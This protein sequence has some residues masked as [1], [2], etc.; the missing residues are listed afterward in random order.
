ML[1]TILTMTNLTNLE[2]AVLTNLVNS[3]FGE[4][5]VGVWAFEAA[6]G[7]VSKKSVA[8]VV[9]SLSKK[10]LVICEY[11]DQ[12]DIISITPAGHAALT[13]SKK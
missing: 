7:I 9:A 5:G 3:D 11:Y 10:G 6:G 12:D 1:R 13:A 8:G 2:A 4:N